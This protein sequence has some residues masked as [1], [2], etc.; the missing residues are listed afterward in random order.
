MRDR[1]GNVTFLDSCCV[2]RV[3]STKLLMGSSFSASEDA[4]GDL[5]NARLASP[6]GELFHSDWNL[7]HLEEKSRTPESLLP[8]KIDSE[9]KPLVLVAPGSRQRMVF[10]DYLL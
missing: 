5:R 7:D 4:D 6:R 3:T 10:Q 2:V 9:E 8:F 1:N